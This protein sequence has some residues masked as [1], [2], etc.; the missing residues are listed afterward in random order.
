LYGNHVNVGPRRR[1]RARDAA[2]ARADVRHPQPSR[3]RR[4]QT[5][6]RPLDERLGL[7]AGHEHVARDAHAHAAKLLPSEDLL[8]RLAR[9]PPLDR[10]GVRGRRVRRERHR[11]LGTESPAAATDDAGEEPLRVGAW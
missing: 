11:Q 3:T 9:G 4:G 10:R 7:G 6:E 1:E 8:E 2:R 5:L